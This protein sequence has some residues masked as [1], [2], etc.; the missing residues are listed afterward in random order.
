M[1][2][3]VKKVERITKDV[4]HCVVGDIKTTRIEPGQFVLVD[5]L[6]NQKRAY[7]VANAPK[8][9][10]IDSIELFI[11]TTPGGP[12]SRY[13]S[14]IKKNDSFVYKGPYGD[15]KISEKLAKTHPNIVFLATGTG[16]APVK[17]M[18]ESLTIGDFSVKNTK[19]DIRLYFGLRY[20]HDI[21][22]LDYFEELASNI[23]YF[24]FILSL[25]RPTLSWHGPSGYITEH[26]LQSNINLN[27]YDY[28][29]CGA[30]NTTQN[31]IELLKGHGISKER[32]NFEH[33]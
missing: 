13:F 20:P 26:L 11:D 30:R 19:R 14:S 27:E 25:S 32:I 18:I 5:V 16:I 31:I 10:Y 29:I 22:L 2:G 28:Y 9:G 8:N 6:E 21:Y 15:F 3:K 23:S 33:Y 12:G 24:S 17:A 1:K 4:I 7:G